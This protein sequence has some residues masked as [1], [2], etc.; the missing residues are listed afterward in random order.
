MR[1]VMEEKINDL[2]KDI[3][4]KFV[5][6]ISSESMMKNIKNNIN[7]FIKTHTNVDV[8]SSNVTFGDNGEVHVDLYVNPNPALIDIKFECNYTPSEIKSAWKIL[9]IPLPESWANCEF[10]NNLCPKCNHTMLYKK[11]YFIVSDEYGCPRCG[12]TEGGG[13]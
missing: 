9:M 4:N 13:Y 8:E 11:S 1:N 6:H 2:I 7:D 3:T 10:S 5:G 12:H